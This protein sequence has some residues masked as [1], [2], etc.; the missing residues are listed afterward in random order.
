MQPKKVWPICLPDIHRD[1]AREMT[2]V[3]G[4][5]ITK[6][7]SIHGSRVQVKGIPDVARHASVTVTDCLDADNFQYPAGLICA[8]ERGKDSCQG[9]SGG[10][11]IG[12]AYK[13]SSST[14]KRY[15]W[16]GI[17]SFGV[18]CAEA[19]YPGAYTRASCFLGFVAEQFSLRADF[20]GAGG[21]GDWSTD[22]AAGSSS[23]ASAKHRKQ[24]K[25]NGRSRIKDI[26][27]KHNKNFARAENEEKSG[28]KTKSTSSE[29]KYISKDKLVTIEDY[30]E[31]P[32]RQNSKRK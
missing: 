3:A 12:T 4:W 2:Y 25:S 15:S 8:A 30:L 16:I 5:G 27:K 32:V 24:Y 10:P 7:K 13:Y 17:V 1:Y 20:S 6:T 9:D 23:R 29:S 14:S 28:N 22:C 21:H 31:K 19:G 26:K 11:L 18:G